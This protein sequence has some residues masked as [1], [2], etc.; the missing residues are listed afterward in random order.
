MNLTVFGWIFMI[1][2]AGLNKVV[3]SK[4]IKKSEYFKGNI[5]S[6]A[7]NRSHSCYVMVLRQ[8]WTRTELECME[9][10]NVAYLCT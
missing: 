8:I 6:A 2:K 9:S 5:E 1:W 10:I 7:L 4:F 3:F